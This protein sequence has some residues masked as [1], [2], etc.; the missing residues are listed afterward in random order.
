[1]L[2][3]LSRLFSS[4]RE[5]DAPAS[6]PRV[7]VQMHWFAGTLLPIPDWSRFADGA[8]GALEGDAA[9]AYWDSAARTWLEAMNEALGDHYRIHESADFLLLSNLMDR[10]AQVFLATCQHA[11]QSGH[12]RRRWRV[13]PLRGDGVRGA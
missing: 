3:R 4:S 8:T 10:P 1:M 7:P 11:Q 2:K 9:H 5:V 12:A 6:R 13:G